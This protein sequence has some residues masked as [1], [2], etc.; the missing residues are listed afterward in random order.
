MVRQLSLGANWLL[1]RSVIKRLILFKKL[2]FP[3]WGGKEDVNIRSG[4]TDVNNIFT[5]ATKTY[6]GVS[7]LRRILAEATKTQGG[8][9]D[10]RGILA[11]A[12][13]TR[14]GITDTTLTIS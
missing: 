11:E 12:G 1:D 3:V 4:I 2:P 8:V 6:G 5:E 7:D 10:L 14:G 9:S 13:N